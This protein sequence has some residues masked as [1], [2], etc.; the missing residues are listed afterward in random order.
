MATKP[1]RAKSVHRLWKRLILIAG[2]AVSLLSADAPIAGTW[3]TQTTTLTITEVNLRT[4][5]ITFGDQA[6][7]LGLVPAETTVTCDGR[8][9][10]LPGTTNSD[11][12]VE[13]L[14]TY[15]TS[16]KI[17]IRENRALAL[18][19]DFHTTNR[20]DSLRYTIKKGGRD[21]SFLLKRE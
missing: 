18:E 6:M 14:R 10:P 3:R 1:I 7:T 9:R 20:G 4:Y 21:S 2:C 17:R 19:Q 12:T 15:P 8:E 16:I 11:T 13:C 5:R